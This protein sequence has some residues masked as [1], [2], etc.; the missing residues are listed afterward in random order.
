MHTNAAFDVL[1]EVLMM[2]DLLMCAYLYILISICRC[3]AS[4]NWRATERFLITK[5]FLSDT[6]LELSVI[7][8][9]LYC[10]FLKL[11]WDLIV[12]WRNTCI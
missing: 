2:S 6:L 12:T 11:N 10:Y 8:R 7:T 9:Y 5:V 3:L 4:Q 1:F